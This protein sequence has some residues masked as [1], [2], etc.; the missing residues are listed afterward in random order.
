MV[1]LRTHPGQLDVL[2]VTLDGIREQLLG[3]RYDRASCA[4]DRHRAGRTCPPLA[5]ALPRLILAAG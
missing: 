5:I 3:W 2:S 4:R 1:G